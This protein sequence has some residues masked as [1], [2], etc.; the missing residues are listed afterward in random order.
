MASQHERQDERLT[1]QLPSQ[2]GHCPLTGRYFEPCVMGILVI[3][4][5][6]S[7]TQFILVLNTFISLLRC[8]L[9][10]RHARV[11]L[12]DIS[13]DSCDGDYTFIEIK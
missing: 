4:N 6:N 12:R 9:S 5:Q 2:F 1:G 3:F 8:C 7:M 10:G 13:K 11:V